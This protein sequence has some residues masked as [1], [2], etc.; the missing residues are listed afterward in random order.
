MSLLKPVDPFDRKFFEIN[1]ENKFF[2]SII[3]DSK[4]KIENKRKDSYKHFHK[5]RFHEFL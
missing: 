4:P 2:V 3:L 1:F 5:K